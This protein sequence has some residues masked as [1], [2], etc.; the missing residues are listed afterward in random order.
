LNSLSNY[1]SPFKNSRNVRWDR[2]EKWFLLKSW[3]KL[4]FHNGILQRILRYREVPCSAGK[5]N[6]TPLD[7]NPKFIAL[8]ESSLGL[9]FIHRLCT[10]AH[11]VFVE[12]GACSVAMVSE[13]LEL[14]C[15]DRFVAS[16]KES[17]QKRL[18]LRPMLVR[19]Q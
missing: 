10:A 7:S 1:A 14:S 6:K 2:L 16:S 17:Q 4:D 18:Q 13:F 11:V 19:E 15:L 9:A 12:A 5:L 8:M 3:R